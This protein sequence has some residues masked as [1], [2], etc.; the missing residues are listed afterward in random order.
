MNSNKLNQEYQI[1]MEKETY[2]TDLEN[3]RIIKCT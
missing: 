1:L 3:I 2:I